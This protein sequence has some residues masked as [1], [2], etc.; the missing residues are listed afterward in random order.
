MRWKCGL[1][2]HEGPCGNNRLIEGVIYS[3][4]RGHDDEMTSKVSWGEVWCLY[5][6]TGRSG[7]AANILFLRSLPWRPTASVSCLLRFLPVKGVLWVM[8]K[9][10]VW[11]HTSWWCLGNITLPSWVCDLLI[12][13][14]PAGMNYKEILNYYSQTWGWQTFVFD[15]KSFYLSNDSSSV[16]RYLDVTPELDFVFFLSIFFCLLL[17]IL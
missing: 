9:C 7:V 16:V 4:E 13:L 5:Q 2:L 8:F 12:S 3:E 6:V 11:V 14:D 17:L 15:L 10:E 1:P